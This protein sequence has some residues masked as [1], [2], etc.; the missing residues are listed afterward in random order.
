MEILETNDLSK[1]GLDQLMS[2][3]KPETL[4]ERFAARKAN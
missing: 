2:L 4:F 1:V 3:L